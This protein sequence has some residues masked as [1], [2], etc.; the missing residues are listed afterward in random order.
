LNNRL[1]PEFYLNRPDIVSRK[2]LGKL[3]I[4]RLDNERSSET[5]LTGRIVEVEAYLGLEDP[6]AHSFSGRTPR[7]EVIF[8][9]PGRAY[10]YFIYGMHY[11]LNV[12]CEPEGQAGCVLIR[13]LEPVSGLAKMAELRGLSESTSPRLL[14]SG[15]G[16]LCQA[17]AITRPAIN[18]LDLTDVHSPLHISDDGFRTKDIAVTPRIGIRKAADRPLRFLLAGNPFVSK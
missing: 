12:S 10:V 2:L 11:C 3:L 18:G 9:P 4:R 14:T 8:G 6:A 7:N 5:E 16:R 13:A 17:M 1:S 15:P